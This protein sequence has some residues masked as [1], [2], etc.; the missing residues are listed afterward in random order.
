MK[1]RALIVSVD[2]LA[3]YYLADPRYKMPNLRRLA[4]AGAVVAEMTTSY[5]SN[6]HG[7]R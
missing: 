7:R 3:S 4:T 5:R 6:R 1:G 2:A